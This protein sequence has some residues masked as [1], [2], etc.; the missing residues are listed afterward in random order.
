MLV[1]ELQRMAKRI[2]DLEA[3]LERQTAHIVDLKTHIENLEGVD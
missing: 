2:E 1:E 3:I